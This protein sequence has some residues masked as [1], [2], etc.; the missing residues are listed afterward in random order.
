[1]TTRRMAVVAVC[2]VALALTLAPPSAAE[3][4]AAPVGQGTAGARSHHRI[5]F[6][7]YTKGMQARPARLSSFERKVHSRV[8]IASYYYGFGDVF[9]AAAE[10]RFSDEGRR[11]V[12][13]SWDMG[14]TRFTEWSG[15]EHDAY[16]D[17][18]VEAALAYPRDV[19]VRPWPEMNGDWQ[20]FQPTPAGEK[21]FG[22]TYAEFREAWRYLVTY[23]RERGA[24]NLKWVF[25][26]T[27][28]TYAETTPVARIWPGE[29]YV[30]VLGLDGFN[31]GRDNDWGRWATFREI[32]TAQYRKLTRLHATAP[33]WICEFA[34]KEP[35][36]S[37]GAPRDPRR[38]KAAWLVDAFKTAKSMKRIRALI[39]FNERKERDWR[40]NSSPAAL[41][42]I[43]GLL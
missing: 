24:T 26:P 39:Y 27:A 15:G 40:V 7:A 6:G 4:S 21:A 8:G 30:D 5:E 23:S 43:R 35:M 42:A 14:P 13:V 33:V 20:Q 36:R 9:P 11:R 18:I 37:D 29:E 19:Y 38:S 34:S 32:F 25:N 22:G 31:W 3:E 28:D 17:Q 41:K 10:E 1:M 16:L 12:L 2:S